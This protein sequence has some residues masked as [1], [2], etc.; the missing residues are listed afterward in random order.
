LP[1]G[2]GATAQTQTQ[3]SFPD[4]PYLRPLM[5]YI[6]A[7]E[8]YAVAAVTNS[9]VSGTPNVTL[10]IAQKTSITIYG[11]I[12]GVKQG[13]QIVQ[14]MPLV[15]L[16]NMQDGVVSPFA[17]QIM[18][19]NDLQID[20]TKTMLNIAS[21]PANTTDMAFCFGVYFNFKAKSLMNDFTGR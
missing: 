17:Q 11:G 8:F 15:R 20:W 13:N 21:A 4:L 14:Q 18:K 10:T 16:N 9:P 6:Q 19:F 7:L 1:A 12:E 2:A 5:A 3:W